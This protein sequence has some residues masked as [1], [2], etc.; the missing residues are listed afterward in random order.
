MVNVTDVEIAGI[1]Y[2]LVANIPVGISGILTT[3]VD[4]EVYF[5]EQFTG[6]TISTSSIPQAYQP[7]ITSLT[8]AS[9]LEQMEA[10][11]IGTKSVKIGEL[12]IEK[13]MKVGMSASE[14]S[15]NNGIQKLKAIGEKMNY[16]QAWVN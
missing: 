7:A 4:H 5:A 16:Y 11:G 14:A 15:R 9:V 8:V 13:G 3:L 6:N 1:V 2:N 10:Q 12:S